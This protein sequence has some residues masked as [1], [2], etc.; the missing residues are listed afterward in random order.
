MSLT[1]QQRSNSIGTKYERQIAEYL[2]GHGF[3]IIGRNVKH[4]SGVEFDIHA[5]DAVGREV[6]IECKAGDS[7]SSMPGLKR[8]DNIWKVGGYL[9]QLSQ[10][11]M[12]NPEEI[13]PRYVVVTSDM[14]RHGT[15][16]RDMVDLWALYGHV[17]FIEVPFDESTESNE[18][19]A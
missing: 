17:E 6:G 3:V 19:A 9:F 4:D 11:A 1:P 15:K 8:S 7:G 16:W 14:P 10:W 5:R 12:L 13:V 18:A 2:M